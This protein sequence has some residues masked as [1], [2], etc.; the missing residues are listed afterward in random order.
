MKKLIS[1]IE[2]YTPYNEQERIDKAV[3]LSCLN[4]YSDIFTRENKIAHMTASAWVVNRPMDKILMIY[5]NI[6]D[7]WSWL[8][9]HADGQTDLLNVAIKEVKEE[10][11]VTDVKPL[12][13]AIFSLESL[14]VDGHIKNGVYV[15][16]HLHLN[17]TYLLVADDAAPL[18]IK[19]DENSNVAWFSLHHAVQASSEPWF[20]DNIYSKLNKK[21]AKFYIK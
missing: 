6:Y 16:S 11:G 18:I 15:P 19:H 2:A 7:S 4:D 9:G 1:E 10:S 3:I 8:G 5:H 12:D 14:T 21:L 20:R 13:T 17:L